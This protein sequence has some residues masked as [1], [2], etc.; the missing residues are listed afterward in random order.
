MPKR[1]QGTESVELSPVQVLCA[2]PRGVPL[3]LKLVLLLGG[4]GQFGWLML[5]I[6]TAFSAAFV[7]M[8]DWSSVTFRGRVESTSGRVVTIEDTGASVGGSENQRGTPIFAYT[9]EYR[10]AAGQLRRARSYRTGRGCEQEGDSVNVQYLAA[11]PHRARIAG[12][13]LGH[14]PPWVLII[15]IFPAV[16]MVMAGARL[17][18]GR[19]WI[20]LLREGALATGH[21]VQK[22]PLNYEVNKKAAWAL[23]FEYTAGDGQT[24]QY[25]AHTTEPDRLEDEDTEPLLY[26]PYEPARAVMLDELPRGVATDADGYFKAVGLRG[27]KLAIVPAIVGAEVLVVAALM[28]R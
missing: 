4:V 16:G 9:F 23:T 19:R 18:S 20:H 14:F 8:I 7:P 27:W 2:A 6:G 17:R 21:L 24:Y 1:S 13:R 12:Q 11:S 25:T 28:L 22:R 15:L 10:D 26:E 5:L 3:S